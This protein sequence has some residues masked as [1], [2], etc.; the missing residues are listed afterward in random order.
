MKIN[1]ISIYLFIAA[2]FAVISKIRLLR[3]ILRS[4][5]V[6]TLGGLFYDGL[7]LFFQMLF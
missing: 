1:H 2:L 4:M 6:A 7:K 3:R 5:I